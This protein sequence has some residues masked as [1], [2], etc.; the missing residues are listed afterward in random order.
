L[1]GLQ[2]QA[3]VL[4][5]EPVAPE[6]GAIALLSRRSEQMEKLLLRVSRWWMAADFNRRQLPILVL[7]LGVWSISARTAWLSQE[8]GT[9]LLRQRISQMRQAQARA[10][11]SSFSD[12]AAP[13]APTLSART[14]AGSQSPSPVSAPPPASLE[15]TAQRSGGSFADRMLTS[16]DSLFDPEPAT[17]EKVE[18]NPQRRVWV[19]LK[20]GLYYCP[21]ADYYGFGGRDRGKVMSQRA[22]EYDYFQPASGAPCE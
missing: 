4:P 17:P 6:P 9:P 1:L 22:A 14:S 18:G 8:S 7:A 12:E 11:M 5:A 10:A 3:P 2:A 13:A 16:I 21:G 20:T 19:D 15:R